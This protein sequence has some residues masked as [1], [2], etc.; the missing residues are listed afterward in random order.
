MSVQ[1]TIEVF[2]NIGI[3]IGIGLAFFVGSFGLLAL[4]KMLPWF[5]INGLRNI[6]FIRNRFTKLLSKPLNK[7]RNHQQEPISECSPSNVIKSL[8]SDG[9]PSLFINSHYSKSPINHPSSL[10]DKSAP[11]KLLNSTNP[12]PVEKFSKE[13]FNNAI[14]TDKSN[15]SDNVDSTK[16]ERNQFKLMQEQ[17]KK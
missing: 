4:A 11:D 5:I 9:L 8:M 10:C 7:E 6:Q 15:T 14:H 2:K 1:F 12:E 17:E 13:S 3:A 16:R